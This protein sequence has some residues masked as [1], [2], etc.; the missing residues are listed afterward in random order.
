MFLA[1]Q[2][3]MSR[4]P[5]KSTDKRLAGIPL[6]GWAGLVFTVAFMVVI[7][8]ALP[9]VRWFLVLSIPPGLLV[10]LI[11]YLLERRR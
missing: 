4:E 1:M 8:I 2:Q 5:A 3:E 6:R 9:A 10:G 11:L 7:L